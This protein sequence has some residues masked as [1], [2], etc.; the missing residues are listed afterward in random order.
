[1]VTLLSVDGYPEGP[2]SDVTAMHN[3]DRARAAG[4]FLFWGGHVIERP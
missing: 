4:S 1:M 3:T 2:G